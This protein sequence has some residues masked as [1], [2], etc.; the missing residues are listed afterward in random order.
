VPSGE[1]QEL[2]LDDRHGAAV[3]STP[4]RARVA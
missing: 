3:S 4:C 2:L 1:W